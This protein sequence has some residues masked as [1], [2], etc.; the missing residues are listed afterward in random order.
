VADARVITD[1]AGA[2]AMARGWD[3]LAVG[4]GLPYCAP[5]WMLAWFEHGLAPA[6]AQLQVVVLE[7]GDRVVGVAPF[8]R[9]GD[10]LRL[11]CAGFT[12]AIGPVCAPGH[13]A[14]LA[15]AVGHLAGDGVRFVGLEGQRGSSPW[16]RALAAGWGRRGA[17]V[18]RDFAMAAPCADLSGGWDAWWASRSKN[19]RKE[20]GRVR[21]RI[22]EAGGTIRLAEDPERAVGELLRLYRLRF[23]GSERVGEATEA[24][25]RSAARDLG[26]RFAVWLLEGPDGRAGS[27]EL[28]VRAGA[29][30]TAWGGGFTE[31]WSR[32][33]PSSVLLLA[34]AEHAA[35]AGATRFDLAEGDQFYKQRFNDVDQRAEWS[36]LFPRGRGHLRARLAEAPRHARWWARDRVPEGLKEKLKRVRAA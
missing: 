25:L 24:M 19:W 28:V 12:V 35:Q 26:D 34:A 6:T 20:I 17:A 3:A 29:E 2:R 14:E 16:P 21:R 11:L 22:A 15:R 33:S 31:E 27:A 4:A 5:G 23:A 13:E 30:A 1:P 8:F 10:R 36:T 9:D 18:H 32:L 7:D